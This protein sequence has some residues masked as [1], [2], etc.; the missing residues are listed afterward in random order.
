LHHQI[1]GNRAVPAEQIVHPGI[2]RVAERGIV[3]RPGCERQRRRHGEAEQ[4][5]ATD[6][7]Q[8]PPQHGAKLAGQKGHAVKA[9]VDHRHDVSLDPFPA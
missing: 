6:L 1:G 9:A 5:Y 4:G 2:G 8:P 7:A 3:H